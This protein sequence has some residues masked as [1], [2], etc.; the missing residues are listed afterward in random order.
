[1]VNMLFNLPVWGPGHFTSSNNSYFDFK[2]CEPLSTRPPQLDVQITLD[3]ADK[4]L[5]A[6]QW[7]NALDVLEEVKDLP[8]ARPFLAR[9]LAELGDS[10]RT[11]TMLWPPLTI[12]EAVT[13]GGAILDG[14]TREEAEA[15]VRLPLVSSSTDASVQDISRRIQERRLG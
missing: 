10:R 8:A 13:I 9:A 12:P 15:F 1:M 6:R 3:R 7:S 5:G 4:H 14:G 2:L 11:I